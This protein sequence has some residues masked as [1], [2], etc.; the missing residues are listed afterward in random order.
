MAR[1]PNEWMSLGDICDYLKLTRP[2]FYRWRRAGLGLPIGTRVIGHKN[3]VWKFH[4]IETWRKKLAKRGNM[5]KALHR[6][7][8]GR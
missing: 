6:G 1:A 3:V 2:T 8:Y 7:N 5:L 4:E